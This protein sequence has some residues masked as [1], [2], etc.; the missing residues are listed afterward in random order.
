MNKRDTVKGSKIFG[1]NR[2]NLV[3]DDGFDSDKFNRLFDEFNLRK[4]KEMEEKEGRVLKRLQQQYKKNQ[5][6]N[7]F[8][9]SFLEVIMNFKDTIFDIIDDIINF[10]FN[11]FFTFLNIFTKNNRL[12]YLGGVL[13]L[14]AYFTLI[15]NYIISDS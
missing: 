2:L 7:I 1:E 9:L 12:F 10:R 15:L 8:D 6:D 5:Q 11:S 4:K 3:T 14:F 13:I